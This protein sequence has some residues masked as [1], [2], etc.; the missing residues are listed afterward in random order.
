[1][2]VYTHTHTRTHGHRHRD[3]HRHTETDTDK[4]THKHTRTHTYRY[5]YTYTNTHT[6]THTQQSMRL[7]TRM[8]FLQTQLSPPSNPVQFKGPVS[9]GGGGE[10]GSFRCFNNQLSRQFVSLLMLSMSPLAVRFPLRM[11]LLIRSTFHF[12]FQNPLV[13]SFTYKFKNYIQTTC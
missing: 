11:L 9:G 13:Y 7:S 2:P 8:S 6:H 1:M 10:R 4:D 3:R 5:T 12:G